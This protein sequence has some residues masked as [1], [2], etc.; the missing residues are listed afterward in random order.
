MHVLRVHSHFLSIKK[1]KVCGF[2][3]QFKKTNGVLWSCTKCMQQFIIAQPTAPQFL[4]CNENLLH[5]WHCPGASREGCNNTG[6]VNLHLLLDVTTHF[7]HYI[8]WNSALYGHCAAF[9]YCTTGSTV[10]DINYWEQRR[11]HSVVPSTTN[12][13]N[14]LCASNLI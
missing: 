10:S 6:N 11:E 8:L 9:Y 12:P 13:L 4:Y 1:K 7:R 5:C 3:I 2:Q 14:N